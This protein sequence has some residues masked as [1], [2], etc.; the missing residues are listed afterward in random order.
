MRL[1]P[2]N[3]KADRHDSLQLQHLVRSAACKLSLLAGHCQVGYSGQVSQ[4]RIAV[5]QIPKDTDNCGRLAQV[6]E[7][8][9]DSLACCAPYLLQVCTWRLSC[10]PCLRSMTS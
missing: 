9:L 4:E 7:V 2:K 8:S 1:Y 3:A 5:N 10:A 6:V